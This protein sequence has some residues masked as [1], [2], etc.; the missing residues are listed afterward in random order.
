MVLVPNRRYPLRKSSDRSVITSLLVRCQHPLVVA[1]HRLRDRLAGVDA[2]ED[3]LLALGETLRGGDDGL[4]LGAGE[5]DDP[6]AVGQD[7]VAGGDGHAAELDRF[8]PRQLLQ[9][10]PGG[11]AH[12]A[13]GE[14]RQ[15]QLASL[16]DVA[17][18]AVD[19]D[20]VD[21]LTDGCRGQEASPGCR[22]G[23]PTA[24]DGDDVAGA[25]RFDGGGTE[26]ARARLARGGP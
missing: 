6:A 13:T 17:S 19:D 18:R 8:V 22:G 12:A 16:V 10:L 3:G 2:L 11:A 7:Q 26:V 9:S 20:A 23:D 15:P 21:A 5:E 24:T 4:G 14:D 25:R 1:R